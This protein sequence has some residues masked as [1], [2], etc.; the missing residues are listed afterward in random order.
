M[1]I[2]EVKVNSANWHIIIREGWVVLH[3][4]DRL[5]ISRDNLEDVLN[6]IRKWHEPIELVEEK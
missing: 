2:K 3:L 1:K 5:M 6:F 4:E